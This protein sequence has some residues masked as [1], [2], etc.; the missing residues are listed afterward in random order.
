MSSGNVIDARYADVVYVAR[1]MRALDAEEIWP[2]TR[3]RTPEDLALSIVSG[4]KNF[5]ALYGESPV[6]AWGAVELR[7]KVVSVWM[8]ATD[9]W[10]KVSLS[11]TRQIKRELIPLLI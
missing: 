1:N 7:P 9:Q 4:G 6:A 8:F 11:V 3:A 10:T 5:V 2:V